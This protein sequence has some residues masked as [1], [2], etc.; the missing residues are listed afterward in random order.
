MVVVMMVVVVVV[1]VVAVV[2][3]VAVAPPVI[4]T[5]SLPSSSH[6]QLRPDHT[7]Q[8]CTLRY[9]S[10]QI[11]HGWVF[12]RVCVVVG[13]LNVVRVVGIT[14]VFGRSWCGDDGWWG[15]K[16]FVFVLACGVVVWRG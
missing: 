8:Q 16:A 1:V 5:S 2:A 12:G 6:A 7:A 9:S 14:W 11:A 10:K 13:R 4:L 15:G 3:V